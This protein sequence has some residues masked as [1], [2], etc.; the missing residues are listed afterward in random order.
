MRAIIFLILLSSCVKS[1][2]WSLNRIQ[3][4]GIDSALCRL[5]YHTKDRVNGIDIAM[6]ASG[7][8]I[9]TYLQ[10]HSEA[11]PPFSKDPQKA[12]GKLLFQDQ[13]LFFLAD[14]HSGG[15]RLNLTDEIQKKILEL[16]EQNIAFI[17]RIDG[18]EEKVTPGLFKEKFQT[19]Q[20]NSYIIP[21][22]LPF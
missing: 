9:T 10:V 22:H 3:T 18:Y 15:Q 16:L 7:A 12:R 13:E 19:V 11:I 6:I 1:D 2:H 17:I 5:Y 14:R 20:Q 4:K 8:K 21:F